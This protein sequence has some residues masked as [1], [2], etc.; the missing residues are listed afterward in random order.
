MKRIRLKEDCG[1]ATMSA[2]Y[3]VIG[4]EWVQ[5]HDDCYVYKEMEVEGALQEPKPEP[6]PVVEPTPEPVEETVE[7]E[8]KEEPKEE[9][10]PKPKKKVKR[11]RYR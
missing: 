1:Y 2:N 5:V 6:E 10:E 9:P 11:G 4:H 8:P 7:E 3:G